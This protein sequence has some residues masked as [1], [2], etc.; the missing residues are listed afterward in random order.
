MLVKE[1]TPEDVKTI[2]PYEISYISMKD[3][4]ILMVLEKNINVKNSF[5]KTE[6]INEKEGQ[7]SPIFNIK[8]KKIISYI[9]HKIENEEKQNEGEYN[10]NYSNSTNNI[11]DNPYQLVDNRSLNK[12]NLNNNNSFYSNDDITQDYKKPQKIKT[13]NIIKD[14]YNYNYMNDNI[15]D[16]KEYQNN[17]SNKI[18]TNNIVNY[19]TNNNLEN[20]SPYFIVKKQYQFYQKSNINSPFEDIKV[21]NKTYN[22]NIPS[23]MNNNLYTVKNNNNITKNN[24]T[25]THSKYSKKSYKKRNHVKT[26]EPRNKKYNI[27]YYYFKEE[28]NEKD[29]REEQNQNKMLIDN[30]TDNYNY[31]EIFNKSKLNNIN[32]NKINN[33][34]QMD[35]PFKQYDNHSY[36]NDISDCLRLDKEKQYYRAKTPTY[37]IKR[38]KRNI[39]NKKNNIQKTNIELK[40]CLTKDNHRF[41]ERKDLSPKQSKSNYIQ[42]KDYNGKTIHVFE[43]K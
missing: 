40:K 1:I 3:G 25:I 42:M 5:Q 35:D 7:S 10:T 28:L 43:N 32:S 21:L 29:L 22:P 38:S 26:P 39:N 20:K 19:N 30:K 16:D 27:N 13:N 24:I 36:F 2:D 37:D 11:Q 9:K 6:T 34:S 41:Y 15:I 8:G 4:T 18:I 31:Y 14:E 12:N 33:N 23:Q 17:N